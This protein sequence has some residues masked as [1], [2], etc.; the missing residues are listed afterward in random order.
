MRHRAFRAL[1]R[2]RLL[3]QL[4]DGLLQA[5]LVGVVLFAP[6][7]APSPT[8]IVLGFAVLLVPFCVVAPLVGVLLD[9]WSRA[10]ALTWAN[11]AR[12]AL[13]AVTALATAADAGDVLVF[14]AALLAL[15]VNRLV[16]AA[17]GA[18]L[19]RTLAPTLGTA[20]T[21]IGAGTGL[22]LRGASESYGDAAPFALAALTYLLAAGG[23]AVFGVSEL[24]PDASE[25]RAGAV[26]H[27]AWRDV[28]VGMQQLWQIDPA[29]RSLLLMGAQRV[30][31]GALT[32]WTVTLIRFRL[33]ETR[34]DE[35]LAVAALAA[36]ALMAGVGLV[37]AAAITPSLVRRHGARRAASVALVVAATGGLIPVVGERVG[38][39][40][41][42]WTF[43]GFGAQA[44]KITLDTV[45]QR[46]VRDELRGRVFIAYDI[47]FNLAFVIG[48]AAAVPMAATGVVVPIIVAV[49]YAALALGVRPARGR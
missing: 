7:Q 42:L 26:V 15:G 17:L 27:T 12:A 40:L 31:F 44:V 5:G 11:L 14:G 35:G 23:A 48:A 47:V 29:R 28:V 33:P 22:A 20:A 10:R 18:G 32:L 2:V 37:S 25:R 30:C 46:S 45:L 39:L 38:S 1:L 16:L 13:L 8:R 19:P 3:G 49:G 6:E 21:V 36:V 43:V 24:G 34:A 9:R 4:A 41:L